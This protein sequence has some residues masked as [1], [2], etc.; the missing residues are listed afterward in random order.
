MPSTLKPCT[1]W[2]IQGARARSD[3]GPRETSPRWCVRRHRF[4]ASATVH[5]GANTRQE[6]SGLS[7]NCARQTTSLDPESPSHQRHRPPPPLAAVASKHIRLGW[8]HF[9]RAIATQRPVSGWPGWWG[10]RTIP[11]SLFVCGRLSLPRPMINRHAGS[12]S[13]SEQ[14]SP[15]ARR[16]VCCLDIA[17]AQTRRRFCWS[18]RRI[19]LGTAP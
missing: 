1:R 14:S 16:G 3:G 18:R 8:V 12:P 17:G 13:I 19:A 4:L 10:G 7:R 2:H 9:A 11:A 5:N 6:E 15:K